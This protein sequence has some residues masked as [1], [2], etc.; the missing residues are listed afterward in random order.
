MKFFNFYMQKCLFTCQYM[1][2]NKWKTRHPCLSPSK[3]DVVF[4]HLSLDLVPILL[5]FLYS[6]ST[7]QPY[8]DTDED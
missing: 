1:D 2:C 6:A 7:A 5:P 4:H 8:I 3:E